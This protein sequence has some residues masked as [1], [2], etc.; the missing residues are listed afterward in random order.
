MFPERIISSRTWEEMVTTLHLSCKGGSLVSRPLSPEMGDC[1][2]RQCE[3][4]N[5]G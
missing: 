3:V 5:S 4:I 2:D 1:A